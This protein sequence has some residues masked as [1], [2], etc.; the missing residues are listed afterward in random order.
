M[1]SPENIRYH[2]AGHLAAAHALASAGH[3]ESAKHVL[4]IVKQYFASPRVQSPPSFR[5]VLDGAIADP[6]VKLNDLAALEQMICHEANTRLEES[7]V[8]IGNG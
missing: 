6:A 8:W 5:A 3:I 7:G 4:G 2:A 1:S